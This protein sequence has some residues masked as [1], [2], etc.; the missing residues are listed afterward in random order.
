MADTILCG[1][2]GSINLLMAVELTIKVRRPHGVD[3]PTVNMPYL[4]MTMIRF[5]MDV[6][7]GNR[8]HPQGR[9]Y[10]DRRTSPQECSMRRSHIGLSLA[11]FSKAI[12]RARLSLLRPFP[13]ASTA[14]VQPSS[15][16]TD[17]NDQ[18]HALSPTTNRI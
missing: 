17:C 10:N 14:C 18:N 4:S 12:N 9:P 15:H 5:G 13:G 7:Q 2:I 11:R 1:L 6:E 8:Q 16:A 3:G